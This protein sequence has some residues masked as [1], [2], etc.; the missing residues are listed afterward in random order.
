MYVYCILVY[1][2]ADENPVPVALPVSAT[3]DDAIRVAPTVTR[4]WVIPSQWE[5]YRRRWRLSIGRVWMG[6]HPPGLS[7]SMA[8]SLVYACDWDDADNRRWP[9]YNL[10]LEEQ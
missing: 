7:Q 9:P 5:D 4:Q 3:L 8:A 6:E 1:L 2:K 10:R